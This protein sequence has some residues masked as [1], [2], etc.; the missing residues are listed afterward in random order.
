M[1]N[2]DEEEH[3]RLK[4]Q[5]IDHEEIRAIIMD[6]FY[7]QK[8][9]MDWDKMIAFLEDVLQENENLVQQ[10]EGINW[11]LLN[12][13]APSDVFNQTQP[14]NNE[15]MQEDYFSQTEEMRAYS[16]EMTSFVH[17]T[18]GLNPRA[19]LCPFWGFVLQYSSD[20]VLVCE[21]DNCIQLSIPRENFNASEFANQVLEL[22]NIHCYEDGC[23]PKEGD[24][25]LSL[26]NQPED[27]IQELLLNCEKCKNS[28]FINI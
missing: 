18:D 13:D 11:K 25:T 5:F 4:Q 1:D 22:K 27:G 6:E 26:I 20:G 15:E 14:E 19:S 12:L 21:S 17:L 7:R 3:E 28:M 8:I 16:E 9:E 2:S 10:D 24:L 23:Y